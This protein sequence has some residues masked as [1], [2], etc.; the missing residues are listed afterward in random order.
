MARLYQLNAPQAVAQGTEQDVSHT[1]NVAIQLSG[2]FVGTY[3]VV[4]SVDGANW[5]N[6]GSALSAPGYQFVGNGYTFIALN[7]T[8]YTSGTPVCWLRANEER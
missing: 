1:L 3:Q 4:G 5:V 7:C 6:I 8:A 2:T